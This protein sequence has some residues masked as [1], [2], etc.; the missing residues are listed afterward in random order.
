MGCISVSLRQVWGQ[1]GLWPEGL[2]VSVQ[3]CA[4]DPR[5]RGGVRNN[6]LSYVSTPMIKQTNATQT[7]CTMTSITHGG[8]DL[9]TALAGTNIPHAFPGCLRYLLCPVHLGSGKHTPLYLPN[10]CDDVSPL[11]PHPF[12]INNAT[13]LSL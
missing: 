4:G 2:S 10:H 6:I 9:T 8:W 11:V 3:L 5:S 1:A 13:E 12:P 7:A